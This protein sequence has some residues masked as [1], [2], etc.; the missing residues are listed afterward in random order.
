[1]NETET[2]SELFLQKLFQRQLATIKDRLEGI[3]SSS[4]NDMVSS[5]NLPSYTARQSWA[6]PRG[7]VSSSLSD[8][9][10]EFQSQ[11]H[12]RQDKLKKALLAVSSQMICSPWNI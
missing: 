6:A 1:M 10:E 3:N 2:I 5:L 8:V 4:T 12:V 9:K 11:R 7:N